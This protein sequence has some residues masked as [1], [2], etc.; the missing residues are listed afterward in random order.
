MN[1][2]CPPD[3]LKTIQ[4]NLTKVEENLF[5]EV[6]SYVL[7]ILFAAWSHIVNFDMAAFDTVGD[8][9]SQYMRR[10]FRVSDGYSQYVSQFHY[11]V[12]DWTNLRRNRLRVRILVEYYIE[13]TIT[14]VSSGFSG[15][16]WLYL[17]IYL[18]NTKHDTKIV[19]KTNKKQNKRE[20]VGNYSV[21][22]EKAAYD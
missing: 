18:P 2:H 17:F 7:A 21:C 16:I 15:Y 8:G 13:P 19:L 11:W 10:L 1:I 22:Y 3:I 9:Y 14:R 12:A 4:A 20:Q 5:G 6:E